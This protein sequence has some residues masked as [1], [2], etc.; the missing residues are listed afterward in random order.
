MTKQQLCILQD[1][2]LL[3]DFAEVEPARSAEVIAKFSNAESRACTVIQ[4]PYLD[5]V[6]DLY[7]RVLTDAGD[8][9]LDYRVLRSLK[10][11]SYRPPNEELVFDRVVWQELQS[12]RHIGQT[13]N[14]MEVLLFY[15]HGATDL[16]SAFEK[17]YLSN[18][19]ETKQKEALFKYLRY[20]ALFGK[21]NEHTDNVLR[22]LLR[23]CLQQ[24]DENDA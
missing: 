15:G 14:L 13:A 21:R 8:S 7:D 22:F 20:Q 2:L 16:L 3:N 4:T 19:F 9:W 23:N 6:Q 1:N 12:L 5:E 18:P 17:K 10:R 24:M 11:A